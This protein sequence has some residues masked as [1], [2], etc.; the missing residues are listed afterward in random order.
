MLHELLFLKIQNSTFAESTGRSCGTCGT[1]FIPYPLSTGQH[2]G[3]PMYFNFHC[4]T[5]TA[6]LQFETSGG[7]YQVISI[8]P[9]TQKF[10][11]HKKNVLNCEGQSS[12]LLNKSSPFH[13]TGNCYVDPSTF[14]S[15]APLKHG[16]EIELSWKSP[17][18][19][20]CSS[21]L[22]CKDW[23]NS[24]CNTT[25]DG[26]KRCLCN[27]NF[28]WDGFKLNCTQGSNIYLF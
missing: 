28:L 18:E 9:E 20:I 1:N 25:S 15:N 13:L 21:L 24:N 19:P 14:S 17:I 26:K 27:K 12:L 4:N 23:P 16:V 2:C 11:I 22:D 8:N 10:L 3:D 5:T 6:E 7:T